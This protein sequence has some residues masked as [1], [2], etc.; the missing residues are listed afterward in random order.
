MNGPMHLPTD[1]PS[2]VSGLEGA[3]WL[4]ALW[5]ASPICGC[6]TTDIPTRITATMALGI[7]VTAFLGLLNILY[8]W[9]LW[10]CIAGAL[11]LRIRASNQRVFEASRARDVPWDLLLA[12]ATLLALAWPVAVRPM[13]DGDSMIYHLPNA[14]S[15]VIHHG[16][17]TTGTRYWWYPPA[18]ELFASAILV[19][20]GTPVVGIAGLLPAIL[21]VARFRAVTVSSGHGPLL[22][23]SIACAIV[24]TPIAAQQIISL[25]NDLWLTALFVESLLSPTLLNLG[26]IA[27]VK[28]Q[29]WFFGFAALLSNRTPPAGSLLRGAFGVIIVIV[30]WIVRDALMWH[31]AIIPPTSTWYPNTLGTSIAAHF[32]TSMIALVRSSL[33]TGIPWS[34]LLSIGALSAVISPDRWVRRAALFAAALFLFAPFGFENG[35]PQLATGASLRFALPLT[36]IAGILLVQLRSKRAGLIIPL[37]FLAIAAGV[38]AT[39]KV[40]ANDAITHDALPIVLVATALLAIALWSARTIRCAHVFVPAL[41]FVLCG[42]ASGLAGA[43]PAAY[44]DDR[45]GAANQPTTVFSF[46][47]T[48]PFDRLVTVGIPAGA[49]FMV[50]SRLDAY[51][52]LPNVC[53]EARSIKAAILANTISLGSSERAAISSCGKVLYSDDASVVIAPQ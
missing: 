35:I 26:T 43:R 15:W 36:A 50:Q 37:A 34:L 45:Y 13:M 19:V 3:T 53:R 39:W 2:I 20:A 6:R 1:F 5:F 48:A 31:N 29:G 52:P 51:D 25:Q 38:L 4:C 24:A 33:R 46:L 32:P 8:W 12:T 22:G 42:W 30:V 18:S 49:P 14:A 10:L 28:P 47:K 27:L 23:T 17:W 9:T 7:L 16:V 11:A 40:Y 21:I 41:F 44:F